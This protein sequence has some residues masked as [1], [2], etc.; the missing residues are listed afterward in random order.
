M[1][2]RL[3]AFWT[4]LALALALPSVAGAQDGTPPPSSS[5]SSSRDAEARAL[6]E[7]GRVAFAD[8][9]FE[10]ALEYFE[11]S[12]ELSGRPELLYNIGTSS[13][14]LRREREAVTAFEAYLEALPD[15]PNRRE[16]EGRLRVLREEIARE[17]EQAAAVAAAEAAAAQDAASAPIAEPAGE[18]AE[19]DEG[20][21]D[22]L[23]AWWLWTIIGVVVAGGVAGAVVAAT[24]AQE[25]VYPPYTTGD[26]GAIAITLTVPIP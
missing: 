13:D 2:R 7:A 19:R 20:G 24:V 15:A 9:R 1:A 17:D 12:H 4:A 14:R 8:G 10:D 5:P 18:T 11:R 21:E 26:G 25:D 3:A 16:V 6:F 22:V 23:T